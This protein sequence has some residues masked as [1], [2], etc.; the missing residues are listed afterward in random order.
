MSSMGELN[1]YIARLQRR[2]RLRISARGLALVT[3]TALVGTVVA[4]WALNRLAFPQPG[5]A[6][7]RWALLAALVCVAGLGL[8]WPLLRL[9]R[10][11]A[12][13]VMEAA[14]PELQQRLTTFFQRQD[15]PAAGPFLELLAADTLDQAQ[16]AAAASLAP[17]GRLLAV[18]GAGAACLGVLVWLIFAGP[19]AMGYGASLLWRGPKKDVAPL[20][21]LAVLPGDV[22]VRRNSDQLVTAQVTGLRPEKVQLFARFAGSGGWEPVAMQALAATGGSAQYQFL[23]AGLPQ[24]VEYY[25]AAG[26]LVSP[27]YKVRVVDLPAVKAIRVTYHYPAWTGMKPVMEEHSGDLRAIEGTDAELEVEMDRPL[28]DGELTL[29]G[30]RTI[31]LAGG[32]G[33][34]YQGAIHMAKDGTYH[35]AATD[36]G[37]VVRLSEDYF[38]ATDK[39]APPQVALDRPG[40]DY[41]ATPIEEVTVGVKGSAEFGLR[42][43]HLHY[44]VNGGADQDVNLL[45]SPG[46]K[47]ASGSYTLPLEDFKLVPGD[48]VS[49]YATAKDG[50]AETRTEITFIQADPFEREFSQSQQMGGGGGSGAGAGGQ[51]D[52][53]E[54]SKREKELIAATWKQQNDKNVTAKD[55]LVQG[56]FLSDAQQKLRDQVMALS[57]RIQSRDLS[58]ANQEFTDF[59]KDMQAAAASM[60]PSSEKLKDTQWK[61]ALP[62][63]QKALQALLR[64]EATFRQIQVAFG[65]QGGGGGGGGSAGRDLA[66]LFDLELDTEKNQYETAQTA[67]PEEQHA[68][69]VNDAL[70]KLDALAKR[71]G[72]AGAAGRQP[73]AEL[74]A[75]L[76][77]GDAAA[78]GRTTRTADAADGAE[79]PGTEGWSGAAELGRQFVRELVWQL[80]RAGL[81]RAANVFPGQ[82]RGAG[83][84]GC[85]GRTAVGWTAN[86]WG[87]GRSAHRAGAEPAAPGGRDHEAWRRDA[88]KHGGRK[89]GGGA[90]A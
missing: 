56:Q 70:E 11:R 88:G 9:T 86:G 19:G 66:S 31:R 79:Q 13:S 50:H 58:A 24:N 71:P 45:K 55:A 6:W 77:A 38:I 82:P 8:A 35:V 2:L 90:A 44:S 41:R 62:L 78:R 14:H 21:G 20:Y 83:E 10:R 59:E 37:Q 48:L 69:D 63:E 4:V 12:V 73:A 65:Q 87:R 76:A 43:L 47:D 60:A 68:K 80:F 85:S 64:A 89:A 22:A 74:R 40:R 26:P 75:A 18:A 5:V 54:I 72:G 39:A 1:S 36:S 61:D 51:N 52:Q 46:A 16:T 57:A 23:F 33:N 49:L 29:D 3:A 15:D 7:A 27:H 34:R 17:A 67:S 81:A 53:T 28:K 25:V 84:P 32:T 42:D 30:G